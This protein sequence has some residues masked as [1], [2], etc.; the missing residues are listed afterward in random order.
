MLSQRYGQQCVKIQDTVPKYF[1]AL[2]KY[3]SGIQPRP[4][5]LV[6]PYIYNQYSI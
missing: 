5:Y 3:L 1:R 4:Y 6:S 2:K